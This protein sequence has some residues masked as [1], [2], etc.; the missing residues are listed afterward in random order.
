M[1]LAPESI[2]LHIPPN[3][4]SG[5]KRENIT[6]PAVPKILYPNGWINKQCQQHIINMRIDTYTPNKTTVLY[7]DLVYTL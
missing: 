2:V 7:K 4:D 3:T 5:T 6:S 1:Y